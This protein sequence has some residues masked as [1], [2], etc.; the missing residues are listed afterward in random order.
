MIPAINVTAPPAFCAGCG[1]EIAH[2]FCVSR[3]L[4]RLTD[5]DVVVLARDIRRMAEGPTI[6]IRARI[7]CVLCSKAIPAGSTA[8]LLAKH[9]CAHLECVSGMRARLDE[10]LPRQEV[11]PASELPFGDSCLEAE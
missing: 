4:A 3:A 11:A 7:D 6:E 10:L 1:R 8:R 5:A 2:L 9:G